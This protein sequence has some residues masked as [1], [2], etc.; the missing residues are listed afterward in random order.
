MVFASSASSQACGKPRA[1]AFSPAALAAG[2][3]RVAELAGQFL[4]C[5]PGQARG[6]VPAGQ[7]PGGVERLEQ[8]P[9]AGQAA[10]GAAAQV[11]QRGH[12]PVRLATHDRHLHSHQMR[13]LNCT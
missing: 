11:A 7:V 12:G 8:L 10:V 3:A 9:P 5:L 6:I 1:G 4:S 2:L 13:L